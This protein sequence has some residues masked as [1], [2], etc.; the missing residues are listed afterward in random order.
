MGGGVLV[1]SFLFQLNAVVVVVGLESCRLLL[2][3]VEL[4]WLW[5]FVMVVV[6][7]GLV[8]LLELWVVL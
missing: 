3:V 6:E 4:L 1:L 5:W 7:G 8:W 2:E